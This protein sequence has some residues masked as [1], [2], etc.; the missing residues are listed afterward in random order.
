MRR[1]NWGVAVAATVIAVMAAMTAGCASGSASSGS[2]KPPSSAAQP[3]GYRDGQV[4]K[5]CL[6]SYGLTR[7]IYR[8]LVH[9]TSADSSG[10]SRA[11]LTKA[12][13]KCWT[14]GETG[15][16]ATALK[17]IDRCLGV[18][19]IPTAHTG[20]PLADVLLVLD[21]GSAKAKTALRFCLRS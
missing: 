17:R 19:H 4:M 15:L 14:P 11:E 1:L 3:A 2:G 5:K 7:S 9:S 10:L 18:E 8:Q 16:V 12:G 21:T 13:E 6:H 20:S